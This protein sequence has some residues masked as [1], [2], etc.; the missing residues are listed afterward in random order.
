MNGKLETRHFNV[1]MMGGGDREGCVSVV[2]NGFVRKSPN[3]LR[4]S[5]TD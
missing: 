5:I 2:V 1:V 4:A 3:P